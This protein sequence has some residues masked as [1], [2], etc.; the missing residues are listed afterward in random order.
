[1]PRREA[2]LST[3]NADL[4]LIVTK[5]HIFGSEPERYPDG[6]L[7]WKTS[8]HYILGAKDAVLQRAIYQIHRRTFYFRFVLSIKFLQLQKNTLFSNVADT[9]QLPLVPILL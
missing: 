5:R 4:V 9:R 3:L 7:L 1:M 8:N 6:M 2:P